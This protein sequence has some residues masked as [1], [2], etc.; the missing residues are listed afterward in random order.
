VYDAVVRRMLDDAARMDSYIVVSFE[1]L[2]ADPE[3]FIQRVYAH[4]GL[5]PRQVRRFKFWIRESM[6][7]DGTRGVTLGTKH[8]YAWLTIE[9][10]RAF[11]RADV[12]PNQIARLRPEDRDVFLRHARES[13]QRLGYLPAP[14]RDLLTV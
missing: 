13:M 14:D 10:M 3:T 1:E 5:D 2:L 12:N 6:D 9:E 7:R 8:A 4:A 11:L